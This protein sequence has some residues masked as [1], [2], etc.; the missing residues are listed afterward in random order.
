MTYLEL[1]APAK[2]ANHGIEAINHGADAVY[3]GAPQF[4]ARSAAC[5]SLADVE[6]LVKYAHIFGSKVFITVNTL[7]FDDEIMPANRMIHQL[8]NMGVDAIIMQDLGLLETDLPPIELHASTQ[9]HNYSIERVKFLESVGFKRVIL[10]RETSL[11]QMRLLR[12]EVKCELE[13]FVQGAL[14]VCFSGQCYLSQ[15]LNQRSGNRGCCSQPCRSTYDLLDAHGNLLRKNE[16][17]LSLKDFN[18]SQHLRSM[19]D[20]GITSFKIEGRL[21]DLSYV[22]N[23]TAYYRQKLDALMEG[24][25][26]LQ[27]AS[28]GK[29]VHYFEPDLERTFNR[30]FTDYFLNMKGSHEGRQKMASF[31]TQK[32]MGKKL[33]LVTRIEGNAFVISS[34]EV[35]SRGDGL[36]FFN[37]NGALDGFNLNQVQPLN[38]H[39]F[40]VQPNRMPAELKAGITLWRNNDYAFEKL[41]NGKSAERRIEVCYEL[42]VSENQCQLLMKDSLGHEATST[43]NQ[44]TQIADNEESTKR[45]WLT[46]LSKLGDTPFAISQTQE[47][48]TIDGPV[49]FLPASAI[50]NLRRQCVESMTDALISS[51]HPHET[52]RVEEESL[53]AAHLDYRSNVINSKAEQFYLHHGATSVEHGVEETHQYEGKAL[54]TTK[55]CLRFELGMCL[56]DSRNKDKEELFLS[57]QKNLLKLDFDCQ[58]C[59]MKIIAAKRQDVLDD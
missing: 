55:Y 33:G 10:A 19:V 5:N 32:S 46:Q 11:E 14:C 50:N 56:R 54:M 6:R 22:K 44:K 41:L 9:T 26:D 59:Q 25:K 58:N 28:Y 38:D 7:L 42:H 15:Y 17:L 40:R 24:K 51:N 2:D 31:A 36:C 3:M 18:A 1:L 37:K 47:T 34:N 49:P 48:L 43:I 29:V 27:A 12:K 21:K 52:L 4:G 30:G 35:L 45:M 20:A 16:H 57:N 23:V 39:T 8:Y 13:S 53:V